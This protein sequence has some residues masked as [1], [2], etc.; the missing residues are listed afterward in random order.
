MTTSIEVAAAIN[1]PGEDH[2]QQQQAN[3]SRSLRK[4]RIFFGSFQ[5]LLILAGVVM[6]VLGIGLYAS[7]PMT[8]SILPTESFSALISGAVLIAL[9]GLVA[10]IV[11]PLKKSRTDGIQ[12]VRIRWV[13]IDSLI[14]AIIGA[15]LL[16]CGLILT[17]QSSSSRTTT[18]RLSSF[19]ETASPVLL[20][21]IQNRGQCCGFADYSDRVLEPCKQY[22]PAVGCSTV[23]LDD[24]NYYTR[25]ILQPGLFALAALALLGS[26]LAALFSLV[27][28][29][30]R[31]QEEKETEANLFNVAMSAGED[32]A[33]FPTKLKRSQPF[34]AWHKAVFL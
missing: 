15:A 2:Q 21:V 8:A 16:V 20:A 9:A 27:R 14:M 13:V 30:L 1:K 17:M 6:A 31:K 4:W 7:E 29:R 34:D 3:Y 5:I 18:A 24:Y 11:I 12:G 19:W 28:L 26:A 32:A 10:F 23:L 33:M 22:Q 25:G